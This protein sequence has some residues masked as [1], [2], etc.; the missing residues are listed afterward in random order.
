[1][2][3]TIFSLGLNEEINYK[4]GWKCL[5]RFREMREKPIIKKSRSHTWSNIARSIN[6]WNWIYLSWDCNTSR[7]FCLRFIFKVQ[8]LKQSLDKVSFSYFMLANK[9]FVIIFYRKVWW[10]EKVCVVWNTWAARKKMFENRFWTPCKNGVV[11]E[12]VRFNL[13]RIGAPFRRNENY[14]CFGGKWAAKCVV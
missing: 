12:I 5:I 4:F 6:N 8:K 10:R 14:I 7:F 2:Q 11:M 1:M 9:F 3:Q 13:D